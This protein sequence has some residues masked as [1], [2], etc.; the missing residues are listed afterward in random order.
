MP[1]L[2]QQLQAA[3][4]QFAAQPGINPDQEAQLRAAITWD[5]NLL[6]QL[7]QNAANGQLKGF[8]LSQA[9][10]TANL[11]GTYDIASAVVTLP[12]TDFS[13]IGTTPSVDLI[14]TLRV[15][16]MSLRFAHTSY[17]DAASIT[18]AVTQDMVTNLQSTINGSPVLAAE[19]KRAVTSPGHGQ[20]A[21]LQ[22]FA[23]LSGTVAGGTYNPTTRTMSLPPSSLA[24]PPAS[25]GSED[26]TFVLGHEIQ[27]GFNAAGKK[28]ATDNAYNLARQIARDT[29]PV[30]DYTSP[31]GAVI[32][33]GR[34]DEARAQI[35]GWNALLSR[36]QQIK[37]GADLTDIWAL[38]KNYKTLRVLDF[39][40]RDQS[41]PQQAQARPGLTFNSDASLSMTPANVA[42]MGQNYFDKPPVGTPGFTRHQTT[43]IGHHGDSDYPNYYGANAVTNIITSERAHAHPI[44]G[45]APRM[46]IDMGQLRLRED[47][48]ER[49]GVTL[50]ANPGTPQSYYDTSQSPPALHHFDH[51][52]TPPGSQNSH[53]HVP[54]APG[55]SP[56]KS[57]DGGEP[58]D[59]VPAHAP[60]AQ[61]E[62]S[63]TNDFHAYLDRMLAAA[64]S[65][66]DAS[67][68]KMTQTLADLPPGREIRAEAVATVDRHE[69]LAA[70]QQMDQQRVQHMEAP[71]VRMH[72]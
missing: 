56:G 59:G 38:A 49:N 17:V 69:Q 30:N 46:Q 45:V 54:A 37:P 60:N 3:V 32:Q 18:R 7:N 6:Q 15:Q 65:G 58:N 62:L 61:Q 43:G 14:A 23:S 47:L 55:S 12:A 67:F 31:I 44:N 48:M 20:A 11:A 2:N 22:H 13:P 27:H 41:N 1:S 57:R 29:N 33:A 8:A 64:R 36:E 66:D 10:S 24:V 28:I 51:T 19:V 26:L 25:F 4:R 42:Q 71:V 68:R 35:A 34:E 70:Q 53:Q 9:G 40:E 5:A 50:T 21:P 72:R 63:P 52:N 16:D 39:V